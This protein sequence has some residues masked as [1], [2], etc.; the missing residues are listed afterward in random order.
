LNSLDLAELVFGLFSGNS[1]HGKSSL[2]VIDESEVLASLL[3]A[4]DIHES[5]RV[6]H[7][8]SDFAIDLDESLH[9]NSPGL[10]VVKSILESVADED[11]QGHAFTELVRT[12]RWARSVYSGEFVEEPVRWRAKALLMLLSA[13]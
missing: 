8:G 7:V 13:F 12:G 1:V 5:S 3:D 2:G 9:D 11:D 10:S 4:N 6:G